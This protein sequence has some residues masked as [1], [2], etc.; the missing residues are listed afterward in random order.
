MGVRNDVIASASFGKKFLSCR[1]QSR[2][3]YRSLLIRRRSPSRIR[4][5][6]SHIAGVGGGLTRRTLAVEEL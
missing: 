6:I 5:N 1:T 3:Q 4:H 2:G